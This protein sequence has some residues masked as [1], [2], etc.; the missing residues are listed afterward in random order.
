MVSIFERPEVSE[1]DLR[2]LRDQDVLSELMRELG[3]AMPNL[4]AALIDERDVYLAQR[5]R[6][7]AGDRIVAVVGAGHVGGIRNNFV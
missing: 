1:D 6:E 3:D 2:R 4:K 7:A 5:M